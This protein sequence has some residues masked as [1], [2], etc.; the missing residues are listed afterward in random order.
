MEQLLDEHRDEFVLPPAKAREFV[1]AAFALD[2][3]VTGLGNFYHTRGI[4]LFNFTIKFH[5]MLH[6]S[7]ETAVIN[8]RM[9]WCYSGEEMMFRAKKIVQASYRGTPAHC[10]A[11][12]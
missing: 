11:A 12:K 6:I 5:Y 4:H 10:W 3:L 9:G 7:L 8:P 2:A 1:Q